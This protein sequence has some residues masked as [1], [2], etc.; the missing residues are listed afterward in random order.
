M[1]ATGSAGGLFRAGPQT[2]APFAFERVA[3][4]TPSTL[5]APSHVR[6]PLDRALIPR[7]SKAT[8]QVRQIERPL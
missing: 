4:R 8:R 6:P 2:P 5:P 7:W 1:K 3:E